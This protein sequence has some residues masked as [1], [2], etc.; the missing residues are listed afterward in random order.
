MSL[1]HDNELQKRFESLLHHIVLPRVLPNG[2]SPDYE[3]IELML[4]ARMADAVDKCSEWIP[5]A[6]VRFFERLKRI[7][8]QIPGKPIPTEVC[9]EINAIHPGEM[10]GMF[11]RR[12]NTAF[13][14]EM[15]NNQNN[16]NKEMN[17][18][19]V[20]TFPG[21]LHPKEIYSY[22]RDLTVKIHLAN[23][24]FFFSIIAF[25]IFIQFN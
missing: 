8:N 24:I 13:M 22:S 20:T 12:Q 2:K 9:S 14:I 1:D 19:I 23:F 10:F 3:K 7:H 21:N 15:P 18:V 11:V 17:T 6:T 25:S 16:A 5:S 4:L